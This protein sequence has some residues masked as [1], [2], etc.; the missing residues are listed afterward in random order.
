ME[1][2]GQEVQ[3]PTHTGNSTPTW[4]C[5]VSVRATVG[6]C[7]SKA[8]AQLPF[9]LLP[10]LVLDKGGLLSK[11]V[12]TQGHP[13]Y[14]NPCGQLAPALRGILSYLLSLPTQALSC[15]T[16]PGALAV[17]CLIIYHPVGNRKTGPSGSLGILQLCQKSSQYWH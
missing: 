14:R 13:P 9:R 11:G 8:W 7:P 2:S 17:S 6:A 12:C 3:Q 15:K 16:Q 4:A 1:S 5:R 10:S